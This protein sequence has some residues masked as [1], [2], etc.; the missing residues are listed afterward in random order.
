MNTFISPKK[1]EREKEDGR[2]KHCMGLAFNKPSTAV[3]G[4]LFSLFLSFFFSVDST[5]KRR[6]LTTV[7]SFVLKTFASFAVATGQSL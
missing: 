3:P 6:K 5:K 4:L 2:E 1:N 7:Q